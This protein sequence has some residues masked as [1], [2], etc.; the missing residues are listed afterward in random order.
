M[1]PFSKFD[2]GD[3]DSLLARRMFERIGGGS[4]GTS[5]YALL[6]Q[7][8]VQFCIS[9]ESKQPLF[10]E[11]ADV[12]RFSA[13]FRVRLRIERARLQ[14]FPRQEINANPVAQSILQSTSLEV[15]MRPGTVRIA[16]PSDVEM[17]PSNFD[18][19]FPPPLAGESHD[20]TEALMLLRRFGA[21]RV[22][23]VEY[24]T[25]ED[26]WRSADQLSSGQLSF[27]VGLM[28]LASAIEDNCIILIDEPEV[29]LHPAWQEKYTQ[30][31]YK[32][33]R[34][35]KGCKFY[36]ATHSPMVVS[37]AK[38]KG[39]LVINLGAE[40]IS[41]SD[42]AD[43]TV[44]NIEEVFAVYFNTLTS[45]S[46]FVRETAIRATQALAMGDAS[47]FSAYSD[48]LRKLRPKV[49]DMQTKKLISAILKRSVS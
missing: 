33:A 32:I 45:N 10:Q 41:V 35:H 47:E 17:L 26:S 44:G 19:H 38:E 20:L 22:M 21:L 8:I 42:V 46:H 5:R 39:T 4:S 18:A 9:D 15:F 49:Q 7:A 31:I 13:T 36:I 28:V 2:S 48:I 27:F 23:R 1:A 24:A 3:A 29:S 25:Q 6:F 43:A 34:Y 14:R 30:L 37:A 12:T 16:T 11:I 40:L